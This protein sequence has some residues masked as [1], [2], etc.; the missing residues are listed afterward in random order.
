MFSGMLA[1]SCSARIAV[2]AFFGI[3][4][5]VLDATA[6]TIKVKD[7]TDYPDVFDGY[8]K[9]DDFV[10]YNP[11]SEML[12]VCFHFE[13]RI[14]SACKTLVESGFFENLVNFYC[15]FLTGGDF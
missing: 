8:T 7:G 12:R 3:H 4:K 15:R 11:F 6:G 10:D 5:I 2:G 13:R 1:F 14:I 9:V